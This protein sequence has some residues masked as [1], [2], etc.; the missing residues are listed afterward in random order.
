[1]ETF[2]KL[3]SSILDSSVWGEDLEVRMVWITMLAMANKDGY[4]GASVD[5]LARRARVS[6]EH[7]R[8]A[9]EKFMAPDPESRSQE[10]EGR[11]ID[12][13]DRGWK[14]LNYGRF[15]EERDV[16]KRREQL[17]NAQRRHREKTKKRR[18]DEAFDSISA[19][20]A[21]EH[22]YNEQEEIEKHG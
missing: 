14:L 22:V 17:R 1:M 4:V 20:L 8:K 3:C 18:Q 12:K 9:L 13:A 15:R 11:R 16:E 6:V 7:T 19:G 10:F 21:P 2:T 5:G